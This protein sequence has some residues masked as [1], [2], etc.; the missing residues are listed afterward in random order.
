MKLYLKYICASFLILLSGMAFAQDE[1]CITLDVDYTVKIS[2][3]ADLR[4]N[5]LISYQGTAYMM[6]GN[7][8]ESYCDGKSIWLLDMEARE[9]YIEPV[10]PETE[11]YMLDLAAELSVLEDKSEAEFL[12]PEGQKVQ[13]RVKSI[14]KTDGKDIS[15]FRPNMDFDSSWV[16]TDLR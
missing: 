16:V 11:K 15:S 10:T 1:Q 12:S 6:K 2:D 4:G 14:K 8:V 7:G 5:A 9:V 3:T 13:I